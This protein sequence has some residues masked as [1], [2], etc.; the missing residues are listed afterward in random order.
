[1]LK[2][3]DLNDV[4]RRLKSLQSDAGHWQPSFLDHQPPEANLVV[5]RLPVPAFQP[6]NM[7]RDTDRL[8]HL[9]S[10]APDCRAGQND[11][12]NEQMPR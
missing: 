8:S 5:W 3:L 4:R 10:V 7:R 6:I 11:A 1:M 9:L 2:C 12:K